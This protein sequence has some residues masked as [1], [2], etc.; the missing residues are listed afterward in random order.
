MLTSPDWEL[1]SSARKIKFLVQAGFTSLS[2]PII[3]HQ[4]ILCPPN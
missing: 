3:I 2:I 4:G 1:I